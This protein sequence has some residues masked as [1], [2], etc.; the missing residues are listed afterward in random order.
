MPAGSVLFRNGRKRRMN[1]I[2]ALDTILRLGGIV[3]IFC[4]FIG[5]VITFI[6]IKFPAVEKMLRKIFQN[7]AG[8]ILTVSVSLWAVLGVMYTATVAFH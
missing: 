5:L 6:Q 3:Y 7:K 2:K 8:L 4:I 1:M